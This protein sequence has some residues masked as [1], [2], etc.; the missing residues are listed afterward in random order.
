MHSRMQQNVIT[1]PRPSFT[2]TIISCDTRMSTYRE[3]WLS[4]TRYAPYT[5]ALNYFGSPW[6]CPLKFFYELVNGL[7]LR[8]GITALFL[9]SRVKWE[10]FSHRSNYGGGE[11]FTKTHRVMFLTSNWV[12]VVKNYGAITPHL[13]FLSLSSF[14]IP[15]SLP[16]DFFLM[17]TTLK[18]TRC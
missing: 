8:L 16:L 18:N 14:P 4:D 10:K 12:M 13:P 5:N 9:E 2:Y 11:M 1:T 17:Q 6:L 15:S 7:L 3:G